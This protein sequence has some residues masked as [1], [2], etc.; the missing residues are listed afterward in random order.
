MIKDLNAKDFETEVLKNNG[1]VVVDFWANWCGPCK[2]MAPVLESVSEEFKE[3]S[4]TKV[5]VDQNGA[6]AD[7]YDILSIPTLL[8]F[9][10]G[11][12]LDKLVGF[13]PKEVLIE[14][15]KK[16]L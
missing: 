13:T 14:K 5:D 7:Q 9:K 1:L 12:F 15:I 4:F 8:I 6:L 10:D 2:M 16:N 3:V 11:N